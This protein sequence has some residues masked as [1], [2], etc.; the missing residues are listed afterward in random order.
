VEGAAGP[1]EELAEPRAVEIILNIA[2]VV[3]IEDVVDTESDPRMALLYRE[4]DPAPD[5]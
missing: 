2:V 3:A 4:A 5:L 1:V